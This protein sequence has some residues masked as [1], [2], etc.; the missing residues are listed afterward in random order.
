MT[1]VTIEANEWMYELLL[2]NGHGESGSFFTLM[3]EGRMEAVQCDFAVM[4][5]PA[6]FEE[7]V[8]PSLRRL[9]EYMDFSMYHLD[10]VC[11]MRFLDQLRSLPKLTGIQWNP[12]PQE[13]DPRG[14]STPSARFA[15]AASCWR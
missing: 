7:F 1:T 4:L 9:T 8:M 6:Q 10:G 15:A 14:G 12:E 13:A 11:Q 3:A 5:S 2:E